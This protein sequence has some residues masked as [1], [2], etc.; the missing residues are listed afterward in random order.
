L[1]RRCPPS[2]DHS[3]APRCSIDQNR[4]VVAA[5]CP[6]YSRSTMV[7]RVSTQASLARGRLDRGER[8]WQLALASPA[9]TLL[10]V[11]LGVPVLWLAGMSI[12]SG[13]EPTLEHY[14]RLATD[15]VY[16]RSMVVT[17]R[18]A[19]VVTV[20][21]VLLGYPVAYVLSQLRGR[22]AAL[23]L[24]LVMI[25][26][27]TSLLVRTYAWLVLLQ[28]QG[29]VNKALVGSGMIEEPLYLVHNEL[30]TVIGMVHVLIP[31]LVLPLYANM[32]RI[33]SG[34]M[35]AAASLGATPVEAFW[36]VYF[37]LSLPGLVAG[38]VLVFV[39]ALG[40]YITPAVLGGG[41]TLMVS[42]LIER[43]VNLFFEW[44][45]A[46]SLAML[47]A[48]IVL[49]LFSLLSRLLPLEQMFGGR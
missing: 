16:L 11:L 22:W 24:A 31:L 17:L 13:G 47:F 9:L 21:A 23:G 41:K 32:K 46:S 6:G 12:L 30:G 36:R 4:A 10:A 42:I 14:Q 7:A 44:G 28:R 48:G 49:A 15:P 20:L 38:A 39:L 29:L 8:L 40:F 19:L 25:P 37:P 34:L 45:A 5:R 27:W 35:R 18:I 2:I 33:D 3:A 26:F 1:Q 43:N